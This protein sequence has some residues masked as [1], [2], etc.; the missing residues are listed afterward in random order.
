MGAKEIRKVISSESSRTIG[1]MLVS[2]VDKAVI[3]AINGY[4]IAGK[5]GTAQVPDFVNGGYTKNVINT[6]IGYGPTSDAKF[7]ILIKLDEPEDAPL[8]G[9]TVVPAFHELAQFIINY[10][11]IPPDRL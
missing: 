8:A 10:Y 11:N 6:Y 5:T 2:A 7:V 4:N 1:K 3:G 9:R